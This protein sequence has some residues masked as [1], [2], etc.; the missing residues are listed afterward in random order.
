LEVFAC[1]CFI[2][3]IILIIVIPMAG[4]SQRFR[5]AGY[6][7][8]KF[9]LPLHGATM[10]D[11]T[12]SSFRAYFETATFFFI[13]R[14]AE[15]AE[16]AMDHAKHLG[17]KWAVSALD[18][19][20]TGLA[21]T[22]FAGF[23]ATPQ[24]NLNQPILIHVVDTFRPDFRLPENYKEA[25]FAEFCL[26]SNISILDRLLGVP[27]EP[28]PGQSAAFGLGPSLARLKGTGLYYMPNAD[29]L[30]QAY[31][32][33]KAEKKK[34]SIASQAFQRFGMP[35]ELVEGLSLIRQLY[36]AEQTI[37]LSI[38]HRDEV[39]FCGIP[40]EYEALHDHW[41]ERGTK[42]AGSPSQTLHT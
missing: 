38:V 27:N 12:I 17:I 28:R 19:N 37:E 18:P 30:M 23:T 14:H 15:H 7:V 20:P 16:F 2:Q 39:I 34:A 21:E 11:H 10:F 25:G 1:W 36:R 9:Q 29:K 6:Q 26:K 41:P 24:L 8:A 31:Q 35:E 3:E 4:S 40:S 42:L 13:A 5:N 22:V 33:A 32:H